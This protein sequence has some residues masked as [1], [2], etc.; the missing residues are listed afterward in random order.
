MDHIIQ[1]LS[2]S[3]LTNVLLFL[4]II[5]LNNMDKKLGLLNR[6][7]WKDVYKEDL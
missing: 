7:A 1:S 4:I 6:T 2:S 3:F 5:S